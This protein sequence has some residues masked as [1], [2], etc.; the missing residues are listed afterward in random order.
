MKKFNPK[1]L[2]Y[3]VMV[4]LFLVWSLVVF[5]IIINYQQKIMNYMRLETDSFQAKLDSTLRSYER[6]ADYLYHSVV[7]GND[8]PALMY[9]VKYANEDRIDE[10]RNEAYLRLESTYEIMETYHFRQLHLHT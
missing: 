3:I 5:N 7:E 4:V 2:K 9:E 8:I 6:F 10:L 1:K